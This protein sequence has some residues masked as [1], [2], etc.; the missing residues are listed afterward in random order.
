MKRGSMRGSVILDGRCA[1]RVVVVASGSRR[2]PTPR[3][4]TV[5]RSRKARRQ[6]AHAYAIKRTSPRT[7]RQEWFAGA[8]V[9]RPSWNEKWEEAESFRTR[10]TA[11]IALETLRVG[12][13]SA[14]NHLWVERYRASPG[15]CFSARLD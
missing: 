2:S 3:Q 8:R 4:P 6:M 1:R 12:V 10:S 14:E 9:D 11:E 5:R 15:R 13:A 7:G